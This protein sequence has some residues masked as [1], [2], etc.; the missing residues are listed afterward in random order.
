V[1]RPAAPAGKRVDI[2][3]KLGPDGQVLWV[4]GDTRHDG[5]WL[6][7]PATLVA[8]AAL[9]ETHERVVD[10]NRANPAAYLKV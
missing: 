8:H 10:A 3:P 5:Y 1:L 7:G 6:D 9:M 2:P 4:R